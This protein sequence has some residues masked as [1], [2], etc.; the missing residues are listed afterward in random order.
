MNDAGENFP[1]FSL[2]IIYDT[3][4]T[5]ASAEL[6]ELS[7]VINT[8]HVKA[9][10]LIQVV[11]LGWRFNTQIPVAQCSVSLG[12]RYAVVIIYKVV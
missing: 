6:I 2:H 12:S 10:P 4:L 11:E 3:H 8:L 9:L 7:F 1:K 5:K